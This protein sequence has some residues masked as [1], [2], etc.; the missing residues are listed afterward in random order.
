[1]LQSFV[2]VNHAKWNKSSLG[3]RYPKNLASFFFGEIKTKSLKCEL[4]PMR[5]RPTH[6]NTDM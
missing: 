1:M 3:L 4:N 2:L 6:T 5:H